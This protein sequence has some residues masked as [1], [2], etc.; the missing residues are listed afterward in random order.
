MVSLLVLMWW[1]RSCSF[2]VVSRL[3]CLIFFRYMCIVF[4]VLLFGLL[5]CLVG[6][7]GRWWCFGVLIV[8]LMILIIVAT[9]VVGI[10]LI[11]FLCSSTALIVLL[12]VMFDD[13]SV[14]CMVVIVFLLSLMS[15]MMSVMLLVWSSLSC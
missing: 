13:V 12:S 9:V 2:F 8:L 14:T 1:V 4:D 5:L 7:R 10:A 15:C 3:T 6:T 11:M